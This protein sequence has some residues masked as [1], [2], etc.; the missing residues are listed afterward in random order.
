MGRPRKQPIEHVWDTR[1]VIYLRVLKKDL[2][3]DMKRGEML[4]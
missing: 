1:V 3:L 2:R 4:C